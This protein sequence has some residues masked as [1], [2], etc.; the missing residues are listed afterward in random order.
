MDKYYQLSITDDETAVNVDTINPDAITRILALAGMT[1]PASTTAIPAPIPAPILAPVSSGIDSMPPMPGDMPPQ[2]IE[3]P[4]STDSGES[5]AVCGGEDHSEIDCPD[6]MTSQGDVTEIDELADFDFGQDIDDEGH[7]IDKGNYTWNGP[8]TPQRMVKGM[9]GDNPLVS[10]L[11]GKI[12]S[13]YEE[14]L[15]ESE[16]EDGLM[17]PLSDPTKPEFDKDPTSDEEPITD[18]TRSPMSRIKR[19]AVFK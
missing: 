19:Q 5:C 15:A 9:Q 18:G 2:P 16:N 10:E 8:S 11:H 6:V 13:D 4:F 12:L 3:M 14:Y 17:S 1:V 7:E